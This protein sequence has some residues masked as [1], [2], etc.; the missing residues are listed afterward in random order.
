MSVAFAFPHQQL[1]VDH[2]AVLPCDAAISLYLSDGQIL[3]EYD[4]PAWLD[5]IIS[6]YSNVQRCLDTELSQ[7][8]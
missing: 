8:H 3:P 5:A 4:L 6:V 2:T 1:Q 7:K